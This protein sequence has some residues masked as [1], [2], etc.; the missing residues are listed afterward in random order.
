MRDRHRGDLFAAQDATAFIFV[1]PHLH[2]VMA[3]VQ[4]APAN[5]KRIR[6]PPRM[7]FSRH[8][9]QSSEV[10]TKRHQSKAQVKGPAHMRFQVNESGCVF[11]LSSHAR[12]TSSGARSSS[13]ATHSMD[14]SQDT[15]R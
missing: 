2:A 9:K 13:T 4:H 3:V 6:R 10:G 7:G 8:I 1:T 11:M 5:A 14:V 15:L 12:Q